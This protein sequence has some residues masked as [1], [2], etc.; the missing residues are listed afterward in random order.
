MSWFGRIFRRENLYSDL[1]AELRA[2]IEEKTEQLMR[3]GMSREVAEH[4]ARR[5]FGNATVIEERS[6]EV[7]QWPRLESIWADAKFAMRQLAKSP[8]FAATAVLTLALGIGANTAVFSVMNAVLLRFLA[9]PDPQQ[10]V[11]LHYDNQPWGTSQSGYGDTS[12]PLPVFEQLR[13]QH[14]VFSDLMAFAPL[15]GQ[16]IAVRIGDDP[17]E[18]LG[19]MVSGNFF[20]GLG[21]KLFMGRGFTDDDETNHTAVAILNYSWWTSRFAQQSSDRGKDAVC[22]GRA[23]YDCRGGAGGVSGGRS[24]KGDGFLDSTAESSGADSLG[25]FSGRAH[26]LRLAGMV[27]PASV[28]ACAAGGFLAAGSC[29][30]STGISARS[31]RRRQASRP[32]GAGAA[33]LFLVCTRH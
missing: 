1:A 15:S 16:K 13:G 18:A 6:R 12:L 27:L 25:K 5:A 29:R 14:K 19:E 11:Y 17:E 23:S 32:K 10:L 7:W 20:S 21:V 28:G 9:V 22:K 30:A 3:E 26:A 24:G 8:A 33:S 31:L 2:H 4:A